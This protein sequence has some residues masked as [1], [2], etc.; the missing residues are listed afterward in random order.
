MTR[1]LLGSGG[2]RGDDRREFL[3][4]QMRDFFGDISQL[5]F[6]PYA[7][8]N[9]D[10]YLTAM[11]EAGFDAGYELVGIHSFDDAV[12]AVNNA[13]AIYVGGGNTFRLIKKMHEN[14]TLQAIQRRVAA[15]MPYM[16]VSAGSNIACPTMQTTNDMPI[17]FPPSFDSLGLVAYQLNAHYFDG[18]TFVKEGEQYLQHFGETRLDRIREFHECNDTPVIGLREG[19]VIVNENGKAIL[20]GNSAVVFLKGQPACEVADGSDLLKSL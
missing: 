18:A 11:I 8:G 5:L 9:Y 10:Q 4:E 12:E 13:Q 16:G 1:V 15:G 20:R 7:G 6:V 17:V 2:F 3:C 14:N 19:S